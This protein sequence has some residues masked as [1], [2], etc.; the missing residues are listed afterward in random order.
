LFGVFGVG[1]KIVESIAMRG[2]RREVERE[3]GPIAA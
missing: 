1:I 2:E 3:T